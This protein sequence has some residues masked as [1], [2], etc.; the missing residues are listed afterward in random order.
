MLAADVVGKTIGG[1]HAFVEHGLSAAARAPPEAY[2]NPE[3]RDF[4]SGAA[5]CIWVV[6]RNPECTHMPCLIPSFATNAKQGWA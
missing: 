2:G 5:L 3:H 6:L 1:N 4:P